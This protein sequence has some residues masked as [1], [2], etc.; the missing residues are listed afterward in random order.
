MFGSLYLAEADL[1]RIN[2]QLLPCLHACASLYVCVCNAALA[3]A[4]FAARR[5]AAEAAE[6]DLARINQQLAALQTAEA[7]VEAM[8]QRFW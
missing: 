2:Q 6:A 7:E 1:T 5:A 8:E 4:P 3:L